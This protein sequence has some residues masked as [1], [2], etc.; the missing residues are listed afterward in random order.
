MRRANLKEISP[1]MLS[2]DTLLFFLLFTYN[3]TGEQDFC[4]DFN[5]S[6]GTPLEN[7]TL[8]GYVIKS[9]LT[10]GIFSCNHQCLSLSSCS[11]YNYQASTTRGGLCELNGANGN[12]HQH[13][14][15]RHGFVFVLVRRKIKVTKF[16]L[17]FLDLACFK[18]CLHCRAT[19]VSLNNR[20]YLWSTLIRRGLERYWRFLSPQLIASALQYL[21]C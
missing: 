2:K 10:R 15:K 9:L 14:V 18:N 17:Y 8:V 3:S 13:L 5:E 19:Q 12:I 11:S 16:F 7:R 20:C 4:S 21:Y 1:E 6:F